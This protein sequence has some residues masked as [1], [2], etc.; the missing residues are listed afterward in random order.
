MPE[1]SNGVPHRRLVSLLAALAVTALTRRLVFPVFAVAFKWI[2]LGRVKP[3]VYRLWGQYY[4]RWWLV[5]QVLRFSG[6]GVF[7]LTP[8][9]T[10]AHLRMLGAR[11]GSGAVISPD[12]EIGLA[13]ADLAGGRISSHH[14]HAVL[15]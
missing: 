4:L 3:G 2:V 13:E 15:L 5:D 11:V 9:L 10:R 1:P 12:A 7:R 6:R 8:G 14:T